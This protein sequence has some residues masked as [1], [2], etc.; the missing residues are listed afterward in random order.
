MKITAAVALA[1]ERPFELISCD[2]SDD[3][4]PGEVLVRI[5]ACGICHTD[6]AV[7]LQHIPV[8]LPKIL[9]HEGAGVIERVG[10]GVV[11]LA[12]GDNVLMSFGSCGTCGQ[13][14]LGAPGYCDEFGMINLFGQRRGGSG[15]RYR[16]AELGGY[17]FAQSAFATHAIATARNVVK[18]DKDLP[19]ALLAPMGCGIQTG[20]GAVLNVLS[21]RAGASIAVFG[22]GAVGMAAIMAA[23][24][25]GCS[26]IVA[27]DV[28]AERLARAHDIGATHTVDG[29]TLDLARAVAALGSGRGVDHSLDTTG[30][31]EVVAASI[32]CLRQRG[33]SAQV[34]APPRGTRFPVEASVLVGG[35]LTVRGVVEGDAVP[36]IFLPRLVEFFRQGRLPLDRIVS[37]YPFEKINQ[38]IEDMETGA[39]V[40]PVLRMS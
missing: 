27:V 32:A 16:G 17:F 36:T 14:Q 4:A 34:A 8:P 5:E 28:R 33:S 22:V 24:L 12:E 31:P 30:V 29:R 2:L 9:G 10:P 35:G 3:L 15:L 37:F 25:A 6:L 11:G 20:A 21:P 26:T 19:L 40:K 39:I 1:P 23:K 18:I 7:K 38:A 13:C